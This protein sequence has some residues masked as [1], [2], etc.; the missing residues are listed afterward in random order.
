MKGGFDFR[1]VAFWLLSAGLSV[2]CNEK[3]APESTPSVGPAGSASGG[4]VGSGGQKEG[5]GDACSRICDVSKAKGCQVSRAICLSACQEMS[6][7]ERCR[8]QMLAALDCMAA[9]PPDA[10]DCG[11]VGFPELKSGH[12]EGEQRTMV[13]CLSEGL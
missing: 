5:D 2:G 3:P 12:C 9:L 6:T 10:W 13:T 1:W 4:T 11:D 8:K 7:D